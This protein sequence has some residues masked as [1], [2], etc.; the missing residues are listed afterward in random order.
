MK[1]KT[2]V[3]VLIVVVLLVAGVITY[4][5]LRSKS[6][7]EKVKI[8]SDAI[9]SR[10]GALGTDIDSVLANIKPDASYKAMDS[11][12]TKLYSAKGPVYSTDHPEYITQVLQGKT[13]AQIKSIISAF[14]NKYNKKLNDHL[15]DIF[16]NLTGYDT[17]GY[18]AVLNLVRN[19]R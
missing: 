11:D 6:V 16:D 14:L 15:N 9:D 1:G 12:L 10:V 2:A 19:A 17:A 13:K 8:I 4:G 3:I 7:K 5:I 18:Q